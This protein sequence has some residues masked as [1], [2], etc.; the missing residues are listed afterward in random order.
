MHTF[1]LLAEAD[2]HTRSNM[3]YYSM[4]DKVVHATA[5]SL[6]YLSI[7]ITL[8]LCLVVLFLVTIAIMDLV[9]CCILRPL[10]QTENNEF[11]LIPMHMRDQEENNEL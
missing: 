3:L 6:A 5:F 4:W 10:Y 11:I 7:A 1:T 9:I 8:I 2:R